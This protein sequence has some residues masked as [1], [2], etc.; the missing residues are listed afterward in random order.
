MMPLRKKINSAMEMEVYD[1]KSANPAKYNNWHPL[2]TFGMG[3]HVYQDSWSHQGKPYFDDLIGHSR[4]VEW[5]TKKDWKWKWKSMRIHFGFGYSE[6]I[7]IKY[8]GY[9]TIGYYKRTDNTLDAAFSTSTDEP[10][11]FPADIRDMGLKLFKLMKKII[12][13][14]PCACPADK[15]GVFTPTAA[16]RRRVATEN[17][18]ENYLK[19]VFSD[20]D[21]LTG[22]EKE[23]REEFEWKKSRFEFFV[24]WNKKLLK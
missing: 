5:V 9:D 19:S 12:A 21:D 24:E 16:K 3:I 20:K 23:K 8:W 1:S 11:Y 6:S 17:E 14:H 13:K 4:G 15:K 10:A 2:E 22:G 7:G 18:V